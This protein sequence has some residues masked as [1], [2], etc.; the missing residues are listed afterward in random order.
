MRLSRHQIGKELKNELQKGFNIERIAN[1][2]LDL[3]IESRGKLEDEIEDVLNSLCLM[4]A[5]PEFEYTEE[6]L[7]RLS[8]LLLNEEKD[9]IK[10]VDSMRFKQTIENDSAK[11]I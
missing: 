10:I 8:E 6:E 7:K 2:A 4:E 11:N 3:T 1:W 5:G 9:S